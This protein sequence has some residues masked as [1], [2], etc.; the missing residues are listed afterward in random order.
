M[1]EE[2]PSVNIMVD[3]HLGLS[4]SGKTQII[5]RDLQRCLP[6]NMSNISWVG[7]KVTSIMSKCSPVELVGIWQIWVVFG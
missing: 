2:L 7:S 3:N 1:L 4:I 5:S 6:R